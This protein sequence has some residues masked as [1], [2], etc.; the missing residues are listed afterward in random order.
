MLRN[1]LSH[2]LEHVCNGAPHLSSIA[3]L[4]HPRL[5]GSL[6]EYHTFRIQ[7]ISRE[8]NHPLAQIWI[9]TGQDVVE[10]WPVEFGHPQITQEE[11]I[12]PLLEQSQCKIAIV[13]RVHR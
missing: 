2:V 3:G 1:L 10:G 4:W 5:A 11:V 8:K 7:D 13:C 12:A 9:L 6:Q